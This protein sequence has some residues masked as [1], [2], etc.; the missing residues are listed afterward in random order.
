MSRWNAQP[1]NFDGGNHNLK[2]EIWNTTYRIDTNII[3]IE[4]TI[5]WNKNVIECSN[6]V[7]E[8]NRSFIKSI[9]TL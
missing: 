5:K 4:E 9:S 7:Y 6:N 3:G 1:S 8:C 2:H